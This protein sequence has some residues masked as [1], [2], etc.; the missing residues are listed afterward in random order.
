M[1]K[2][3]ATHCQDSDKI[4]DDVYIYVYIKTNSIHK[5]LIKFF[6]KGVEFWFPTEIV[7]VLVWF[8]SF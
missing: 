7:N 4:H 2:G 5:G 3:N 6:T 1:L 8:V